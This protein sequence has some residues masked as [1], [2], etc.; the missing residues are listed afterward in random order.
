MNSPL[1]ILPP[2]TP[3]FNSLT[4]EPGL[5]T[6]NDRIT[7]N[8]GSDVKSRKGTGIFLQMYS[9]TTFKINQT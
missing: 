3:P 1:K 7:I 4:S 8:R 9:Q 6:S 5:L 2:A